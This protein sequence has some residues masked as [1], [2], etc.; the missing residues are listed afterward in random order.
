MKLKEEVKKAIVITLCLI[1]V[2]IL[3]ISIEVGTNKAIDKC[4]A[5]GQDKNV[6]ENGLR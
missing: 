5:G 2:I 1:I 4:V 6:C 3:A